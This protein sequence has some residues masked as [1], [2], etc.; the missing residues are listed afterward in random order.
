MFLRHVVFSAICYYDHNL[1]YY[2]LQFLF[3]FFSGFICE[4]HFSGYFYQAVENKL[5]VASPA[6]TAQACGYC[7][8]IF[9]NEF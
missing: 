7:L 4:C 3:F 2:W 5:A 6:E 9:L 8:Y 1:F